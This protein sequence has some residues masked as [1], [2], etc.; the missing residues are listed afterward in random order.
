MLTIKVIGSEE[1][2]SLI[3]ILEQKEEGYVLTL[4]ANKA[5]V[6]FTSIG[7]VISTI[8]SDISID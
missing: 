8:C 3:G 2:V 4:L 6:R 7:E 1:I 5:F